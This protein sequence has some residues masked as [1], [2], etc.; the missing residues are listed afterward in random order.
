MAVSTVTLELITNPS[1]KK[2]L[3]LHWS[4]SCWGDRIV[5]HLVCDGG[6]LAGSDTGA[7]TAAQALLGI[8]G[9]CPGC[10][11]NFLSL[12]LGNLGEQLKPLG[13]ILHPSLS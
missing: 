5:P 3:A 8:T 2:F 1:K 6:E 12:P 13:S 11:D 7:A 9:T 4:E 10:G